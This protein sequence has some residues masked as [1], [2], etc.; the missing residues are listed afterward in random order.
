MAAPCITADTACTEKVPLGEGRYFFVYRSLPLTEAAPN[1]ERVYILVHGLHRDG[2]VYYKTAI[3]GT[4]DSHE[5][6]RTLVIAPQFHAVDGTC[7][8]KPAPGEAT[9]YCRGWSDGISTNDAPLSSFT[10]MDTLLRMVA[11]REL[12][13]AVKEIV[14][15]GH[16]AGGQ[17]VQ[18]YAATNRVDGAL[19]LPIRYLVANPS[20]YLYLESWRTVENPG[21]SCP[22]FNRY[23]YGLEGM[24][25]YPLEAGSAAIKMNY[26]KRDV[27]YLLGELDVTDEHNMDKTCP[28][29]VQ[30][31]NRR[32]RGMT[33]F[34]R[35]NQTFKTG[36]KLVSV[37]G[38]AHSG[39]CMY[40]SEN[41]KHAVFQK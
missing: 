3:D 38:C 34:E 25:G 16:S 12:F 30:G 26:P 24:T 33:Y 35:L 6:E 36:H 20:S 17:F 11:K 22:K 9:F 1:V 37:P 10:A 40:R 7:K 32:Q 21:A 14:V 31:P 5:M 18:R 2:Q 4:Q 13:P 39:Q 19:G 15:A 41:G 29:M 8:D 23:K 28:A 27:T